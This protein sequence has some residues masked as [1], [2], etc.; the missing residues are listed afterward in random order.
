MRTPTLRR[1][2]IASLLSIA[3]FASVRDAHA[4]LFTTLDHPLAVGSTSV[5]GISGNKAVGSYKD[6][7]G[8]RH[9]FLYDGSTYTTID[10][11]L[12]VTGS[13]L[14]DIDGNNMVGTYQDSSGKYHGFRYDGTSYTTIDHPF[15]FD[16]PIPRRGTEL[17]EIDGTNIVGHFNSAFGP[18]AFS[19]NG[20]AFTPILN[21]VT[22]SN[23]FV[24]ATGI[25][26]NLI[27]GHFQGGGQ[28][29]G[30]IF[31]GSTYTLL[32]VSPSAYTFAQGISG[33]RVVGDYQFTSGPLHGFL[34]DGSTY[35]TIDHPLAGSA[36]QDGTEILAISGNFIAGNYVDASHIRHG[37]I[38]EVPEPSSLVLLG[39]GITG[40][41]LYGRARRMRSSLRQTA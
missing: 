39:L 4:I 10:N 15:A 5:S 29:Q 28:I 16:F 33:S 23:A 17:S 32:S 41:A 12:G 20:S 27:V 14:T 26:G 7:T 2:A 21:P 40:V 11:P 34:Y 22:N 13:E 19:Y 9:G 6:S 30:Y 38:A 36:S 8:R 1:S 35:T 25:D 3:L 18:A 24:Y 37:F 31:D